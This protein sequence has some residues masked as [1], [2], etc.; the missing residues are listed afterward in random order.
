MLRNSRT[1]LPARPRFLLTSP[2]AT[3]RPGLV[4]GRRG[5]PLTLRFPHSFLHWLEGLGDM[6]S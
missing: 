2:A 4:Q 3:L 6:S 1:A 5:H